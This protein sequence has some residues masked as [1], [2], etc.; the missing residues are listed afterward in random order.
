MIIALFALATLGLVVNTTLVILQAGSYFYMRI[1]SGTE[2]NH[3]TTLETLILVFGV[4]STILTMMAKCYAIYNFR[5]DIIFVPGVACLA[6]NALG[7]ISMA[8]DLSAGLNPNSPLAKLIDKAVYLGNAYFSFNALINV[9]LTAMVGLVVFKA[10][11]L[12]C[13]PEVKEEIRLDCDDN[14]GVLFT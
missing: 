13:P 12:L 1:G 14:V 11:K 2:D 5:K 4:F 8:I 6:S 9:I 7:I 3:V 10:V